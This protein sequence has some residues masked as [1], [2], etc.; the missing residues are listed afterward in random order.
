M[1]KVHKKEI[2]EEKWTNRMVF[3]ILAKVLLNAVVFYVFLLRPFGQQG[4]HRFIW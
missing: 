1:E 4:E 3:T 2:R